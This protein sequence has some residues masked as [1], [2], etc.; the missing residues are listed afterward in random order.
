MIGHVHSLSQL[1]VFRAARSKTVT[2]PLYS[3]PRGNDKFL[4]KGEASSLDSSVQFLLFFHHVEMAD[5]CSLLIGRGP[6]T[7]SQY[8]KF[9]WPRS[10]AR[11]TPMGMGARLAI[12]MARGG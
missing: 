10:V 8:V 4:L 5:I 3:R 6:V 2:L 7:S 9:H 1:G 11:P 12:K